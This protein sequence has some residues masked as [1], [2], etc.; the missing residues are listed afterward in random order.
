MG[1]RKMWTACD[2]E[3]TLSKGGLDQMKEGEW[4]H[5]VGL[6][7]DSNFGQRGIATELYRQNMLLLKSKGFKGAVAETASNFS[8]RAAQKNGVRV[9]KQVEYQSYVADDGDRFFAPVPAPHSHFTLW[10]AD[11]KNFGLAKLVAPALHQNPVDLNTREVTYL[12]LTDADTVAAVQLA[13]SVMGLGEPVFQYVLA[14]KGFSDSQRVAAILDGCFGPLREV[15]VNEGLSTIA[16]IGD[17]VV[18]VRFTV[19]WKHAPGPPPMPDALAEYRKMWTACDDEW[20]LSKGGLDQ[21]KEGEWAHFVGLAVDPSFG[22]KGIATE[23]YRQNMLHLKSKGF[24]GAVAETA[25]NFSQ[26]AAQKNGFKK[27]KQ[28]EYRTY[29]ADDGNRFFAPVPTPH[30]HFTLWE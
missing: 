12:T 5:F 27:F 14:A 3:W 19:D 6:A 4:A 28:I 23:L 16:K 30:T 20:T 1:Y 21:M 17:Q 22:Q 13:S 2:D 10:E 15:L 24:K 9:F 29:V 7:V 25:S 26:R 11:V 8:Q 18:G